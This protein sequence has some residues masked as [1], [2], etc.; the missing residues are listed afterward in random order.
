MGETVLNPRKGKA[1]VIS[2][3][4]GVGKT[5][6][7][8]ALLARLPNA[9]WSVS[10]TTRPPRGSEA[11][12]RS[13]DFISPEEFERRKAAG[14][15]LETAEYVGHW[16]GTPIEPIPEALT[17]GRDVVME[18]D[19]QGGVQ[20]ARR[21]PDSVRIFVLSPTTESL[22]ARLAGRKTESE[23][24][25]RKRLSVADGEIGFARD[26]GAYQYFVVNDDLET[27]V[28]EVMDIVERERQRT[29]G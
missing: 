7:C 25:L 23:D 2:G 8:N 24:Q 10:A 22:K 21:I 1:I 6:I 26:S 15:F 29:G 13:Y 18:I 28:A 19:V 11:N 16:Y 27:T 17:Q 20:V 4:S 3:P 9:M 5:S 14:D 12:G